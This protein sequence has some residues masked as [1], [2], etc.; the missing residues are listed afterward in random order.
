MVKSYEVM[1]DFEELSL[2]NAKLLQPDGSQFC[3][4]EGK[5][6]VIDPNDPDK[7]AKAAARI[8]VDESLKQAWFGSVVTYNPGKHYGLVAYRD[9]IT[10]ALESGYSFRTSPFVNSPKSAHVWRKLS[11]LGVAEV[12]SE[13][14]PILGKSG[15]L[16]GYYVVHPTD[17]K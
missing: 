8:D 5:F 2:P 15:D 17:L 10:G 3:F 14:H 4:S 11:R 6:S 7:I 16:N 1:H 13:F 12:V 9:A